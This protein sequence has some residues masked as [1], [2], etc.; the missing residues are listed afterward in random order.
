MKGPAAI[1]SAGKTVSSRPERKEFQRVWAR[2]AAVGS[3]WRESPTNQHKP[4][5][6]RRKGKGVHKENESATEFVRDVAKRN[7]NSEV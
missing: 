5:E 4:H 7:R 6:H 1:A 2:L 3:S